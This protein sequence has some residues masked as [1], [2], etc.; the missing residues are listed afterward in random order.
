MNTLTAQ[1]EF[2]A[3]GSG[4]SQCD[5]ILARLKETPGEWVSEPAL[6]T[7][8]RSHAVHARIGDLRKRGAKEGFQ[9]DNRC[10]RV[11]RQ[12]HSSYKL[13]YLEAA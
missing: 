5:I 10:E 9:I 7:L 3:Q 8:S 6:L 12:V 1:Q 4:L 11:G 2:Q 13:E